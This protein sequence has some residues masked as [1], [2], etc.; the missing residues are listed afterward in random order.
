[1]PMTSTVL[2]QSTSVTAHRT[3]E[4]SSTPESM[5]LFN[6]IVY[7]GGWSFR[8][9]Q[10]TAHVHSPAAKDIVPSAI[11]MSLSQFKKEANWFMVYYLSVVHLGA[12]EG[13]R[14][15][16]SCKWE[17][18]PLFVFIY[19]LTGLG[20]TMGAHRLWAHRSYKAHGIVRFFLMLCNCM[21]NQGTIFHWS[22]DHRVHHKYSDTVA[23]PHDSG[24]GFFFAHMGWLLVKKDPRV[25]E[26]G[27]KL[28]YD[29]L[30][31][32]W[33]VVVQEKLNPW[34][35]LFMC[36]VFPTIVGVQ[37]IG[38]DWKNA[39]FILGFLRYVAVLHA[40]WLV[41]SAA[42]FYGYQTYDNIPPRE[43]WFVSLWAIGEGWHNWH[44]K[45][46]YDYATSEFG[47]TAQF[48]PTK[49][50]IDFMA[51]LGLVTDR[52]RATEIWSKIKESKE[53]G[54]K[55]QDPNGDDPTQAFSELK[56]KA[57]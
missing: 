17:T 48:N 27:T 29:D 44:H 31:A 22:R 52:K 6:A 23:D 14:R 30:W 25:L 4:T 49:L 33:T 53:K 41:N 24:R 39:L 40:T 5:E 57:N 47:A 13:L 56:A 1:M 9:F 55:F 18:F 50:T 37:T 28:N 34:G 11:M 8:D 35:N 16:F 54:S 2:C 46:P 15:L 3:A 26:A 21:A 32:D 20:I 51:L 38:E 7:G 36:F 45:F 12:L 43:N 42:H 19:Y 10:S